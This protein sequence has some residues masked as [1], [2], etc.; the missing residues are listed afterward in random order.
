MSCVRR[1]MPSFIMIAAQDATREVSSRWLSLLALPPPS[2]AT[3]SPHSSYV[4]YTVSLCLLYL[5]PLSPSAD[6]T[7]PVALPHAPSP[8]TAPPDPLPL[9][10]SQ[11]SPLILKYLSVQSCFSLSTAIK[12]GVTACMPFEQSASPLSLQ[13]STA[14]ENGF[15]GSK[16]IDLEDPILF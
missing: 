9:A 5:L 7:P 15:P 6:R 10:Q 12:G 1:P 16:H 8:G 2:G 3:S 11:S 13:A 14:C 4:C